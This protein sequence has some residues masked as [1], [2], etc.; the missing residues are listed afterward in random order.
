MTTTTDVAPEPLSP[1]RQYLSAGQE[2]A[3]LEIYKAYLD[4]LGRI[5]SRQEILRQ[6]YLSVI[7][8]LF[9]FLSLAGGTGVLASLQGVAEPL[10]GD[11][12]AH[13]AADERA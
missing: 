4:D 13:S 5:G 8:A 11:L 10:S 2:Q 3:T 6:F 7:S 12:H 1:A 9:V